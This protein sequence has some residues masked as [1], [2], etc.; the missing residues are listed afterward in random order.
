[1]LDTPM[2]DIVEED[3]AHVITD[4]GSNFILAKK[5]EENR[6]SIFDSL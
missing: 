6:Q 3:V 1:M 2:D 4:N 5:L